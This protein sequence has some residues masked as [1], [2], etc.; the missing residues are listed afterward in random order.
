[1][2][3][4]SSKEIKNYI[5]KIKDYNWD[6]FKV[7]LSG[8]CLEN[9]KTKDVDLI[10]TG[11]GNYELLVETIKKIRETG[12]YDVTFRFEI[13]SQEEL[14]KEG[15]ILYGKHYDRAGSKWAAQRPGGFWK[16]SFYFLPLKTPFPEFNHP[17]IK[18]TI[19]EPKLIYDGSCNLK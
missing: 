14:K 12:P 10:V 9:R 1:M 15:T 8:S 3:L 17:T 18:R 19:K 6:T 16:N 5:S 4:Y 7:Y 2:K 13:L 11:D